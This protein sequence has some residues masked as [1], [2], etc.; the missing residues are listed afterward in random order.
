MVD[1]ARQAGF[2]AVVA[3]RGDTGLAIANQLRPTAITLDIRLPVVDGWSVLDQLK[4]NPD[5]RHI[6]VHVISIF[7]KTNRGASMGAFA[8]LEKPVSKEALEGA[9]EHIR[10]FL[11]RSVRLLLLVEDVP[12]E[13]QSLKELIG[14]D[15]DVEITAV[16]SA[17]EALRALESR[18]FDCVVVD[19][20][21]PDMDGLRLIEQIKGQ[22]K[23]EDLPIIVYTGRNLTEEE[24]HRL[25]R[26]AVSVIVK[27]SPQSADRLLQDTVLFMHRVDQSVP[28]SLRPSPEDIAETKAALAGKKVLVVDDDVRNVF[29]I[30]SSL[31]THKMQ[32]LY[33]ENGKAG[34]ELLDKNP[35][36]DVVLMD[37]MMPGIDGYQT[38]REIRS[39]PRHRLLPII[40]VTARALK[41]DA[42]KCLVAGASDYVPKPVNPDRLMEVIRLWTR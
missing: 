15:R 36:V 16:A 22:V 39:N 24:E 28:T 6:P 5:T 17:A 4:R 19:L 40:A 1:L 32:V 37:V 9:L 7:E 10:G 30:T 25:K 11:D 41:D 27:S 38:I 3:V 29:A 23:F 31:E 26:N 18:S 35:D 20:M 42:S 14:D 12:E 21:L 33:A 13:Q 8:Y 2:K 34:I